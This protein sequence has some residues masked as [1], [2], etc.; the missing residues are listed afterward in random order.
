MSE[1]TQFGI[2]LG[3]GGVFFV[4]SGIIGTFVLVMHSKLSKGLF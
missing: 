4:L 1:I 3:L 2:C